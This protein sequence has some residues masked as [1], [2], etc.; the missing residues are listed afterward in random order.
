MRVTCRN[1]GDRDLQGG[2]S[3]SKAKKDRIEHAPLP[4]MDRPDLRLSLEENK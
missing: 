4:W 2:I 1:E 3:K